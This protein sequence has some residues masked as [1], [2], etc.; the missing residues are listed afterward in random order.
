MHSL[1][2]ILSWGARPAD[3]ERLSA[4]DHG[5]RFQEALTGRDEMRSRCAGLTSTRSD[6]P[7]PTGEGA[8]LR[9]LCVKSSATE[10]LLL[11]ALCAERGKEPWRLKQRQAPGGALVRSRSPSSSAWL[12][13]VRTSLRIDPLC[14]L[15]HVVFTVTS[16]F[17]QLR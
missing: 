7:R 13:G 10:Q 12:T 16:S 14:L 1:P 17:D 2:R 8:G 5:S 6:S 11:T 3:F 9:R 4:E 15:T